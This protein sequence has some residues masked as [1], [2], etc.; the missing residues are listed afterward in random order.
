MNFKD[1]KLESTVDNH[2]IE[3]DD[4]TKLTVRGY[5]PIAEKTAL[6]EY[7]VDQ[8]LD[9]NTGRFSPIRVETFFGLAVAHYYA[10]IDFED[11]LNAAETYDILETSGLMNEIV[12][13]IPESEY[14]YIQELMQ[15]TV[16]DIADF[17]SSFAGILRI[18]QTDAEGLDSRTKELIERIQ[19]PEGQDLATLLKNV[20]E[21]G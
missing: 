10:D 7:V 15:D 21:K 8:A 3:F 19:G 17:N 4:G 18:A 16:S 5:L 13:N 6:I 9:Q 11:G 1:L 20:V 2:I 14:N 12:G